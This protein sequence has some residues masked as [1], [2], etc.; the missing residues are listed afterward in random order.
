MTMPGKWTI[1]NVLE[2]TYFKKANPLIIKEIVEK[3]DSFEHFNEADLS[4]KLS[5]IFRQDSLFSETSANKRDLVEQQKEICD[6]N[7]YSIISLWD[8][9]YPYLLKNIH[10]PPVILFVRGKLQHTNSISVAIVGKRE[11]SE[12]GRKNAREFSSFFASRNIIVCSGLAKG[13]DTV[14]H[15]AAIRSSGVTYAVIAS[16]LDKIS[17][18]SMLENADEIV[19]SGGAIITEYKCGVPAI[20]GYFLQRNRII[21]GI[22]KCAI[23]IESALKG[24]SLNTASNALNESREVYAVP[25]D[26]HSEQSEGCNML[27]KKGAAAIALSPQSVFEELGFSE[28]GEII[29]QTIAPPPDLDEKEKII[30]DMIGNSTIHIDEISRNSGIA[31]S[32]LSVKLLVMEFK[33]IIKQLPGNNYSLY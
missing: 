12:T 27:I 5:V 26:I 29:S 2:L 6:K 8:E 17:P 11:C 25:G 21:S 9:E 31:I 16:G 13:I 20:Q 23:I 3:Y 18:K 7:G 22:S 19:E 15:K 14:S 24:G 32:E 1:D 4:G 10:T 28:N 30:Y 33:D